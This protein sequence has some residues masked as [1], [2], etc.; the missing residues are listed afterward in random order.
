[1]E[2]PDL[3]RPHVSLIVYLGVHVCQRHS[4]VSSTM[5]GKQAGRLDVRSERC[6]PPSCRS[7]RGDLCAGERGQQSDPGGVGDRAHRR[8]R[9]LGA[10]AGGHRGSAR[11]AHTPQTRRCTQGDLC[12]NTCV[13]ASDCI[14]WDFVYAFA[15]FRASRL[16]CIFW[17]ASMVLSL[18]VLVLSMIN[19]DREY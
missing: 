15:Y 13:F 19:H 7:P 5:P 2:R 6:R 1:M 18:S 4:L 3:T 10:R 8:G 9:R 17:L 16:L 12:V 11:S 14:D